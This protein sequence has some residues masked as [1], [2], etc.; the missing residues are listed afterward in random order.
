[1]IKVVKSYARLHE[2]IMRGT[3]P[4]D[5]FFS[6][7]TQ[8]RLSLWPCTLKVQKLFYS[9]LVTILYIS[10]ISKNLVTSG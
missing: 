3:N 7:D 5:R 9:D 10:R 4:A 8:T 6:N 2:K 1:M